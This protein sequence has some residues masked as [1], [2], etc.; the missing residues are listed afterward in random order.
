MT[1]RR[2]RPAERVDFAIVGS[3]A[4]GGVMARELSRSGFSVVLFEQGRYLRERELEL[5]VEDNHQNDHLGT[6]LCSGGADRVGRL[7]R[8]TAL[9]ASAAPRAPAHV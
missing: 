1:A 8:M 6:E 4:A 5:F 9:H 2:F 3:G 7:Q